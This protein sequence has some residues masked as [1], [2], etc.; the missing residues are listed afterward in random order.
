MQDNDEADPRDTRTER[1]RALEEKAGG[2]TILLII[3]SM[4]AIIEALVIV[5]L[6][7]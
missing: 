1:E 3:V 2:R 6:A 4:L 7:F 5:R